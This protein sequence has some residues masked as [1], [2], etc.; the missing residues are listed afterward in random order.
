MFIPVSADI[1]SKPGNAVLFLPKRS[2]RTPYTILASDEI[3]LVGMEAKIFGI[4]IKVPSS[5]SFTGGNI[6]S[7]LIIDSRK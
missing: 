4:A 2:K 1:L 3:N 6:S 7:F 5:P